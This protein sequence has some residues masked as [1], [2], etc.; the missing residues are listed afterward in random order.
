M[1]NLTPAVKDTLKALAALG[2]RRGHTAYEVCIKRL[3]NRKFATFAETVPY[4]RT[5]ER[6]LYTLVHLKLAESFFQNT[7]AGRDLTLAV[8]PLFKV[9]VEG[10]RVVRKVR[11]MQ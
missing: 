5:T 4:L 2:R 10:Q 8:G 1:D 11:G 3:E 9:T 7:K 6:K